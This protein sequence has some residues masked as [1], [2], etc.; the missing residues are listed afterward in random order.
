MISSVIALNETLNQY[1]NLVSYI[2]HQIKEATKRGESYVE[3]AWKKLWD[4]VTDEMTD[5][6]DIKFICHVRPAVMTF[7]QNNGYVVRE[8]TI[9]PCAI[10]DSTIS[11]ALWSIQ[12][13]ELI[14]SW[15]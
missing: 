11:N 9:S 6:S 13:N 4:I 3:V 2:E 15:A 5:M 7:V 10:K 1:K 8:R 14:I 12:N